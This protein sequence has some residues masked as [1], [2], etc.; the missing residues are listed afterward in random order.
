MQPILPTKGLLTMLKRHENSLNDL[1]EAVAF[2]G[3]A[4]IPKWQLCR[5]FG[6][7]RFTVRIRRDIRDRWEDLAT[8]LSWIEDRKV[9]FAETKGDILFMNEA[10]FYDD[11][12]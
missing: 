8:E 5:W 12:E 11:D 1:L 4:K 3:S 10:R 7:E 2:E 6:Q 9:L